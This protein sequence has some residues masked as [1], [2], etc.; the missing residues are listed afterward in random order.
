MIE[1]IIAVGLFTLFLLTVLKELNLFSMLSDKFPITAH[2]IPSWSFFAPNPYQTDYFILYRSF[3]Q[4][5]ISEWKQAY[6][7]P[8]YRSFYTF[9]WHPDKFFLKSIVDIAI[10]LLRVSSSIK[11]K[12]FICLSLP[13]LHTLNFIQSLVIHP[14]AEKIQ[15]VI[16]TRTQ[17]ETPVMVF[18]SE[19]HP[20]QI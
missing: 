1:Y 12:N 14:D 8:K 6:Q 13:Y 10:D 20:V 4:N 18:L 15:F 16:M 17:Q 5:S 9:F 7:I 11:N 3:F 2:F 19:T